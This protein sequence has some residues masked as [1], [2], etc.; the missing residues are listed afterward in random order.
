MVNAKPTNPYL[1]EQ[2]RL[3]AQR[4][5]L[6][7]RYGLYSDDSDDADEAPRSTATVVSSSSSVPS[8]STTSN[9]VNGASSNHSS[10]ATR[11]IASSANANGRPSNPTT[12]VSAAA[13]AVAAVPAS[14]KTDIPSPTDPS[15]TLSVTSLALPASAATSHDVQ[16]QGLSTPPPRFLT[17][18]DLRDSPASSASSPPVPET[19]PPVEILNSTHGNRLCA[20]FDYTA[21]APSARH[22]PPRDPRVTQIT[23]Y[24]SQLLESHQRKIA[25]ND[26][27]VSYGVGGHVRAMLRHTS[28]RCL[29]KGHNSVVADI[30][31]LSFM[32]SRLDNPS[33]DHVSIL[34][35][36]ADDGSVYVWKLIRNGPGESQTLEVADAIRFEHPEFDKGKSY[37]RIA[38]RPGPNSIIA[39]NGIGVA[40]LLLDVNSV[41]L[42]I[43]ELVKMNDKMMVRD[44]FLRARHEFIEG[45]QKAEGNV[46][47][48]AWLSET[49]VATSRGGHVFLWNADNTYSCCIAHV[50]RANTQHV[51]AIYTLL[52]DV[53]LLV[54]SH[55]RELEVWITKDIAVDMSLTTLQLNQTIRLFDDSKPDVH[56]V[57]SI[58]PT[59]QLVTV[60]NVRDRSFFLLH[61]NRVAKAFDAV[62]EVPLK[63]SIYSFCV[64]PLSKPLAS[65][66][67]PGTPRTAPVAAEEL[68]VWCVQPPGIQV[69]HLPVHVCRP[70]SPVTPD[71][72]PRPIP[73]TVRGRLDKKPTLMTPSQASSPKPSQDAVVVSMKRLPRSG[74]SPKSGGGGGGMGDPSGSTGG[75]SLGRG[76]ISATSA[77]N[78]PS[79]NLQVKGLGDV[80]GRGGGVNNG[81]NKASGEGGDSGSKKSVLTPSPSAPPEAPQVSGEDVVEA[82]LNAA[83]KA[84]AS[85]DE[86][87]AQRSANEK[88]KAEKLVEAVA[89]TAESNMERFVN[90]S[91]KKVLAETLIPGVSEI[92]ADSRK[93]MKE[94]SKLEVRLAGEHFE[95]VI[96]RAD[97]SKS[98]GN[99]CKEMSRQV[100]TSVSQSMSS[101]YES[102]IQ[103]M[104]EVVNDATEDLMT[105]VLS[106][107]DE[108]SK[109][110][111]EE[112]D[113]A[114]EV[115]EIK[116]ED[117]RRTIEDHI[118]DGNIDEAFLTALDKRDVPLVMWV[119]GK[120][121]A[122]T[123]FVDYSLS[124]VA[125][126]SLAAQL[127]QKLDEGDVMAKVDWLC[128]VM[129]ALEPDS[130][131]IEPISLHEVRELVV[132]VNELRKNRTLLDEHAGLERKLKTL[133]RLVTSHLQD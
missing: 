80:R 84:I 109:L 30:E 49:I 115:A 101:K 57:T 73:K 93:A 132:K 111:P 83:K 33:A 88:S 123:F 4:R 5:M 2:T 120:F 59:E 116:P 39:E 74:I 16:V 32:E 65:S 6:A 118:R 130:E 98:F 121:D 40:M 113:G 20:R 23:H 86:S 131:E 1:T 46:V 108:L 117:V 90:S 112:N 42:R 67:G 10:T 15:P 62:T 48:A 44:K 92:I 72:Y 58:D 70:I 78:V 125:L 11:A 102:I 41:D 24:S 77:P 7:E 29:L 63:N 71:I 61:F 126:M 133:A 103:P 28:A 110:N 104:V 128:E 17:S 66:P 35:S 81:D 37:K 100:S 69:V 50:P 106:L 119:C 3:E 54:V 76:N 27:I 91:M 26:Q 127:G 122:G 85:F 43:V 105:N 96:E 68:G 94:R 45:D 82:V 22:L 36:V 79:S 124:Q 89:E 51:T 60:S 52:D 21:V 9:A 53:M 95:E 14:V 114:G 64:T 47:A 129:V 8:A 97:I 12:S 13:A 107:R 34:G 99:A 55:G 25:V 18:D 19:W 31:F 38:F 87:A 75:G 56:C